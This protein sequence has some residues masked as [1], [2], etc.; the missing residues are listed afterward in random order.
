MAAV[1]C[2]I[3]LPILFGALFIIGSMGGAIS[4][5]TLL[6]GITFVSLAGG[7]VIGATRLARSWEEEPLD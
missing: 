5:G 2:L 7:L 4:V 1:L 3:F 6:A